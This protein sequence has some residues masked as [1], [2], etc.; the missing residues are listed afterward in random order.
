MDELAGNHSRKDI[1]SVAIMCMAPDA[2][3]LM[4]RTEREY[5]AAARAAGRRQSVPGY[6]DWLFSS[7]LVDDVREK[8]VVEFE[9]DRLKILENYRGGPDNQ[10]IRS[11]RR[12]SIHSFAYWFFR[13]SGLVDSAGKAVK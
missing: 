3:D 11:A 7:G 9:K 2:R 8:A 1:G 4:E 12:R 5:V 6:I 10:F 13:W